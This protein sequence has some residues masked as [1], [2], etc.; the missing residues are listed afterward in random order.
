ME[1]EE[2]KRK[3]GGEERRRGGGVIVLERCSSKLSTLIRSLFFSAIFLQQ[4]YTLCIN[5]C[6]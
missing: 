1:G 2:G 6:N 3:E 4:R 5:T